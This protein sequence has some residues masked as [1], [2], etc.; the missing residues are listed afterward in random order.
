MKS[1]KEKYKWN[2]EI[3]NYC[4]FAEDN[5]VYP[6]QPIKLS[7]MKLDRIDF[8]TTLQAIYY[9]KTGNIIPTLGFNHNKDIEMAKE[10]GLWD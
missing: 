9:K 5:F 2:E 7:E 6:L 10:F 3:N 8:A 1:G 4:L